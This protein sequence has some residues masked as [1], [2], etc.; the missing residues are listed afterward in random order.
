VDV[1]FNTPAGQTP[2]VAAQEVKPAAEA[3]DRA[4]GFTS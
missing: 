2:A 3:V 4:C 1:F